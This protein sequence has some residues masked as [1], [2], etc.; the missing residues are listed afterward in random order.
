MAALDLTI[1]S[2]ALKAI[3]SDLGRQE[4]VPWTGSAYLLTA[5]SF[6]TLYG[7]FAE[8]F[9]RKWVFLFALIA[10]ELGSLICGVAPTMEILIIGRAVAGVGGGGLISMVVVIV[11]DLVVPQDRGKYLSIISVLYGFSS[12]VG[13]LMGGTFSDLATWRWCFF[14]NI[15]F[16][17]VTM[18][19][20]LVFLKFPPVQGNISEKMK[21]IDVWGTIT[22]FVASM[23]L[24]TPLQL[25]GS[26]FAWNSVPVI[27]MFAIAFVAFGIFGYIEERIA[28]EPLVPLSMFRNLT[29]TALILISACM[30][31]CFFASMYFIALFFQVVNGDSAMQAGLKTS[32]LILGLVLSEFSGAQLLTKTGKYKYWFIIGPVLMTVGIALIS[33]LDTNSPTL[34]RMAFL[35]IY[36]VGVGSLMLMMVLTV[37][38]AVERPM[39]PVVTSV[40]QTCQYLGGS[41]GVAIL[42]TLF[43]NLVEKN[44]SNNAIL[45]QAM[46]TLKKNGTIVDPTQVLDFLELLKTNKVVQNSGAAQAELV[47]QFMGAFHIAFLGLLPFTILMGLCG[48]YVVTRKIVIN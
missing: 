36:G 19:I 6:G 26:I 14:L 40:S 1:V 17:L 3:T 39:I 33:I 16:G 12:V 22:F 45:V 37:Q 29:V 7:K 23:T 42:G 8:I 41:L 4:L 11:S 13:P 44:I 32:P 25:G 30:G 38:S 35:F 28:T 48:V 21:R 18:T 15:P 31:A 5:C 46:E 27:V 43:N 10:F 24:L 20:V 9:G 34:M 47:Q 2:T